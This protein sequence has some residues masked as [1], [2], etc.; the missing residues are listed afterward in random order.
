MR[1]GR[2]IFLNRCATCHGSDGR[3]AKGFPNL[4]DAAWLYGSA[5][6]TIQADDHQWPHRRDAGVSAQRSATRA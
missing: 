3:G 4:T 2:N 6:E 1:L 5:P